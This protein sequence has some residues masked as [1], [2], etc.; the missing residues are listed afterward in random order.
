MRHVGVMQVVVISDP[1]LMAEALDRT[2]YPG[3]IDKP[4]STLFYKLMDEVTPTLSGILLDLT[5][6]LFAAALLHHQYHHSF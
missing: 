4:S 2:K 1:S 6:C 5:A 3:L